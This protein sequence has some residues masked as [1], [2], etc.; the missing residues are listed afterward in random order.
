MTNTV[1][2]SQVPENFEVKIASYIFEMKNWRS[3]MSR[4]EQDKNSNVS[5][6]DRHVAYPRPDAHP[7]VRA[8]VNENNEA[9]FKIVDDMPT[10]DQILRTKKNDLIGTVS[11]AETNAISNIVP[12][13]KLRMLNLKENNIRTEAHKAAND[14]TQSAGIVKKVAIAV[15]ISNPPQVSFSPEDQKFLQE[16]D[17][18]R[19]AIAAIQHAAAQMHSDIEDLTLDNIDAWKMPD[20]PTA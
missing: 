1:L 12:F 13:G 2:K 7:I 5:P 14:A 20:F 6:I 3:H 19:S 16:Q 10:A 8:S 17:V 9:D 11:I 15:G 4:V 18:R